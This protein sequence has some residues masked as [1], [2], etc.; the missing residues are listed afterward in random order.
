MDPFAKKCAL[1]LAPLA[2]FML[3]AYLDFIDIANFIFSRNETEPECATPGGGGIH[4]T[5]SEGRGIMGDR[6]SN[7]ISRTNGREIS[8]QMQSWVK[9][10][11][12]L[13]ARRGAQRASEERER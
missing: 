7:D 4:R 11:Q 1:A 10:L 3:S 13:L 6:A 12:K 5:E 9:L 8:V 2:T